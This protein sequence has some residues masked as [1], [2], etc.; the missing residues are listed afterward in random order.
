MLTDKEAL[1]KAVKWDAVSESAAAAAASV[2]ENLLEGPSSLRPTLR[3]LSSRREEAPLS[4][5]EP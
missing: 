5:H 4:P 2:T 1:L 3:T